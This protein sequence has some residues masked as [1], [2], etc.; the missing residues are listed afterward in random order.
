M[1]AA[2]IVSKLT[3]EFLECVAFVA[4]AMEGEDQAN[5]IAFAL[6]CYELAGKEAHQTLAVNQAAIC[7]EGW[8][9]LLDG[10]RFDVG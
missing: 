6:A 5:G 4:T 7:A 2:A 9:P 10:I 8:R 3:N 1:T